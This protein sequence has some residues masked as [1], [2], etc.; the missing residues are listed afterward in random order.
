MKSLEPSQIEWDTVESDPR[1]WSN[2]STDLRN[3]G[4]SD[5]ECHRVM[6]LGA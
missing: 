6:N 2:W 4:L 3:G 5:N 1:S